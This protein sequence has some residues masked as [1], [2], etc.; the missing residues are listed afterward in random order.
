[1]ERIPVILLSGFLGS[2]KTTFLNHLVADAKDKN[3]FVIMNEYGDISIDAEL[4][5]EID[6]EK[7]Y[8][9]NSNC[10]CCVGTN[11]LKTTF[12][13]VITLMEQNRI[14]ID[15]IVIELS[16]LAEPW[17]I[18]QTITETPFLSDYFYIDS[19]YTLLD[20]VNG[21]KQLSKYPELKEQL[22]YADSILLTKAE[23]L[24]NV[25]PDLMN[26]IRV[27]NPFAPVEL[28]ALTKENY[29]NYFDRNLFGQKT[30]DFEE[31]LKSSLLNQETHHHDHSSHRHSDISNFVLRV[32]GRLSTK[33]IE[34]WLVELIK[35]Y[36]DQLVRFK[37]IIAVEGYD[38]QLILQGVN[39]WYQ[40]NKGRQW[41]EDEILQSIIVIIGHQID[42]DEVEALLLTEELDG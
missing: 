32:P 35:R 30:R 11:E 37:G 19:V 23:D 29:K 33:Q 3:I 1:M 4:L 12:G 9:I 14:R 36:E 24:A 40:L 2:G 17:P 27:I 26:Q 25:D 31:N 39:T 20:T 42:K 16:G 18:I 41:Q 6:D 28:L 10:M 34:K 7:I 13:R 21:L 15:H 38:H 22:L 5:Y 8:E